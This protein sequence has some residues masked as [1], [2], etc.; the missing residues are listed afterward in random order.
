MKAAARFCTQP[1]CPT[2]VERGRC[3]THKKDNQQQV[4]RLRGTA[5]QR[6]YDAKWRR[7]RAAWLQEHPFCG[8]TI[9]APTGD[10]TCYL[11][12][13]T[14]VDHV[15]PVTSKDDHR[16]YAPWN[17]QSLC[18]SCHERKRQRESLASRTGGDV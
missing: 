2:L 18:V 5:A 1:G 12:T 7:Y 4:D 6:G 14:V 10:S 8:D 3:A 9:G 11:V 13:A 17:H 15:I 16:F